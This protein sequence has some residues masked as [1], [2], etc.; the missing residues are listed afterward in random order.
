MEGEISLSMLLNGGGIELVYILCLFFVLSVLFSFRFSFL[1]LP[2]QK[3]VIELLCIE[4]KLR[5]SSSSGL[6]FRWLVAG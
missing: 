4:T 3:S 6:K 1:F 2:S 5:V